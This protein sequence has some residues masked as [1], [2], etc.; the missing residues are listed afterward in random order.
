[1]AD[2]E[3]SKRRGTAPEKGADSPKYHKSSRIVGLNSRG[4]L[5]SGEKRGGEGSIF[6]TAM[7]TYKG[8]TQFKHT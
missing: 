3:I 4:L 7:D 8:P 2:P 1:V 6:T 5:T